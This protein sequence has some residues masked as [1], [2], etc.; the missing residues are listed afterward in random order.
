MKKQFTV[1]AQRADNG[2]IAIAES[3]SGVP[4]KKGIAKDEEDVKTLLKDYIDHMFDTPPE[5]KPQPRAVGTQM[6]SKPAG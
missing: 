5:L 4:R 1:Q 2:F 3:D 6:I